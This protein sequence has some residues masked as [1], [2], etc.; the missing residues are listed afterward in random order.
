MQGSPQA[1][2]LFD[3]GRLVLGLLQ[4]ALPLFKLFCRLLRLNSDGGFDFFLRGT[5]RDSDKL[6][7][8]VNGN[9]AFLK[10]L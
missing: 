2:D 6:Q 9:I 10:P 3:F 1:N 7:Q 4:L 8:E 5:V